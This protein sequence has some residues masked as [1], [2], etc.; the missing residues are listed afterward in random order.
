MC[1]GYLIAVL[2]PAYFRRNIDKCCSGFILVTEK[3]F[4][5]KHIAKQVRSTTTS[6]EEH[7][8]PRYM[9]S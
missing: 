4:T 7:Q 3:V 9:T 6:E 2:N 5:E 8:V 1:K